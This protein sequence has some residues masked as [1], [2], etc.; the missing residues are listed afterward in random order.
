MIIN[1]C[2]IFINI[3]IASFHYISNTYTYHHVID[4]AVVPCLFFFNN[5]IQ[6]NYGHDKS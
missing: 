4:I 1:E 2:F 3:V 6:H 5:D